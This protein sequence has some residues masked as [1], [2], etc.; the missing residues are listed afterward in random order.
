MWRSAVWTSDISEVEVERA[1][2]AM[3]ANK[4]P[5]PSGVTSDLLKFAGRTG[6]AQITNVFQKI[7]HS[8]VCPEEW[9]DS[10]TLPF[11]KGKGDPLQCGKY[12]GLRLLEHGMKL[13]EKIL[14]GRLKDVVKIS[15]NQF[16]FSA[17]RS[18]TDAIFILR[19]IQQKYTE[20]KK[21]L[22]H[23]FVDLEKAFDRVPR[24]AIEWALRR[25]LVPEKL[26]R[27]VMALYEDARSSVSAAGGTSAPFEISVGVHQG[28][29]LSPLLFNLVM[30]EATKECRRGVPWDMLYADDLVLT[31]ET[32]EEVLEQFNRWKS[33]MES[34]GLKVNL[35]KTKILVSGKECESVVTSGEHPCSVCGRGVRANSVLCTECRKWV[36]KRCSGLRVRSV[37]EEIAREYVCPTCIRSRQGHPTRI[38]DSIVLGPAESEMV[39]EVESFCYLGSMVDREGGVE[40]AVRSRVAT[41]WT[42]WREI[43]G[44]LGNRRIPLKNRVH[45]YTACIRS[46]LLYGAES[47]P[48]TQRL[49][50]CIQSCDRRMLR[51]LAG[52]SLRDRVSSAEVA[53]RC[54][55][56]EISDVARVRRLQWFGH[57]QRRG[58]GEPLSVVYGWQVEGRRPR[59]RPKKSW[60]KTVEEDMR[61]LGIHETLASD[62]QS[63]RAAVNRPTPQSGN[64]RR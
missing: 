60:T 56:Q 15:D 43:S 31:A 4:A 47:W 52:V 9:K 55:L 62:R 12:R 1:L 51:F 53:R 38:D 7:M 32:K 39:E 14:D 57:V 22:Y 13:W 5:G 10:T 17:G 36:H 63:W 30:D 3:K 26:V 25:Q 21:K 46:V 64:Q 45:I 27:Q 28:S 29:A 41:A 20:K 33:A 40:R 59:G 18:T 44:L 23:I 19:Q 35:S 16:G 24:N 48:L 11:F 58:E 42:K 8:E 2:R 6:I 61:L 54:G 50:Q 37:T 49:E 34:K